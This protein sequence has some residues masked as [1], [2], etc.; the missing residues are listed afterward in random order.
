MLIFASLPTVMHFSLG[1]S[2]LL[3]RSYIWRMIFSM[4]STTFWR[5]MAHFHKINLNNVKVLKMPS[6]GGGNLN[7]MSASMS[8]LGDS[9]W[10]IHVQN[11]QAGSTWIVTRVA[12]ESTSVVIHCSFVCDRTT[13]LALLA[14][15]LVDP[16]YKTFLGFQTHVEKD[17]LALGYPFSNRI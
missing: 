17:S 2:W 3:I 9:G 7:S 14:S 13:Q 10:L 5:E 6:L 12:W 4:L 11:V 15:L 8:T 16:N 1:L